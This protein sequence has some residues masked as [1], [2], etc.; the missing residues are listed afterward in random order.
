MKD[1]VIPTFF[2]SMWQHLTR[3]QSIKLTKDEINFDLNLTSI[4]KGIH[5][6][7]IRLMSKVRL[8]SLV[9]WGNAWEMKHKLFLAIHS[10]H[11][12]SQI[13][14]IGEVEYVMILQCNTKLGVFQQGLIFFLIKELLDLLI[15]F[16]ANWP[17]HC[18]RPRLMLWP[19][20]RERWPG[21]PV[22]PFL[23]CIT[24]FDHS[25]IPQQSHFST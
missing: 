22:F 3:L 23:R 18:L 15:Q 13:S 24:W 16:T 2:L 25:Q 21:Q 11:I 8:C 9:W 10:L 14:G 20:A 17:F 6:R 1:W 7:K 19:I 4:T 5:S 12:L